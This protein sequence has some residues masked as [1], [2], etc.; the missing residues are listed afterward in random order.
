MLVRDRPLRLQQAVTATPSPQ[1]YPPH[2]DLLPP[3][4]N[5][6]SP[7]SRSRDDGGATAQSPMPRPLPPPPTAARQHLNPNAP[8]WVKLDGVLQ[9]LP[10]VPPSAGPIRMPIPSILDPQTSMPRQLDTQLFIPSGIPPRAI[11]RGL[12]PSQPAFKP[13]GVSHSSSPTNDLFAPKSKE[14]SASP[15]DTSSSNSTSSTPPPYTYRMTAHGPVLCVN[16]GTLPSPQPETDVDITVDEDET[17]RPG[18]YFKSTTHGRVLC[19]E[20][21]IFDEA[22]IADV[23]IGSEDDSVVVRTS[24]H[25]RYC[26]S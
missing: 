1:P 10:F 16:A 15:A 24:T 9:A 11:P 5:A 18:V 19:V 23:S 8:V 7:M 6:V 22:C 26:C 21:P 25:S 14:S 13:S 4:A 20:E 3:L 2:S 12:D 17:I